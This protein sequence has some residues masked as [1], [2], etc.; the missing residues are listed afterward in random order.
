MIAGPASAWAFIRAPIE[1]ATW[2]ANASI[3][4][5]AVL[6]VPASLVVLGALSAGFS[7]LIVGLGL[8]FLAVA[9]E[10]SRLVARMERWRAYVGAANRPNPPPYAPLRGDR[11]ALLRAEFG[12]E[13]RWRDV[14]YVIVNGPLTLIELVLVGIFWTA[15]IGLLT[16]P[17]WFDLARISSLPSILEPI[18]SHDAPLVVIRSAAG[19]ALLPVAA[20]ISRLASGLHRQLVSSLICESES[21]ALRRQVETLRTSRAAALEAEASELAAIERDLHDGAQARLVTLAIDLALAAERVESDPAA[22]RQLVIDGQEQAHLAL[23]DIRSLVR[24]TAPSILLDRGLAAAIASIAG[25]AAVPT[26]VASTLQP[27]ERLPPAVERTAYFVVSEA[28]ANVAKHSGARRCDVRIARDRDHLVVEVSDDGSG[29]AVVGDAGGLAGLI[30]RLEGAAGRLS[31]VSPA[32]GPTTV[33]AEI[34]L[35]PYPVLR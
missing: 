30:K 5:G 28:L 9:I 34:P 23:A 4:L 17:L 15:A 29:G 10:A 26:R 1:A 12:D 11:R 8:G 21:R 31:I 33:R 20:L 13:S 19:L 27:A 3:L 14:L 32:G 25:R 16:M 35:D 22:A 7:T 2:R 24:G 18:A 6:G